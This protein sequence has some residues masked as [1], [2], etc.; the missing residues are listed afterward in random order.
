MDSLLNG[1]LFNAGVAA[2]VLALV[3][4]LRAGAL[5][6]GEWLR[7]FTGATQALLATRDK[8]SIAF[9]FSLVAIFGFVAIFAAFL[10]L[11]IFWAF[12]TS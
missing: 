5:V 1:L 9:V 3:L 6:T 10:A 2:F 8:K 7:S 4:I 12:H 11:N